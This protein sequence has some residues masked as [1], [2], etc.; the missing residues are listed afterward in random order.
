MI[1]LSEWND[2]HEQLSYLSSRV[3][4][5]QHSHSNRTLWIV[6]QSSHWN[7]S[8]HDKDTTLWHYL[9]CI[10]GVAIKTAQM[11]LLL[12]VFF[13]KCRCSPR[14]WWKYH[15]AIWLLPNVP[16]SNGPRCLGRNILLD[17]ILVRITSWAYSRKHS[18][19]LRLSIAENVEAAAQAPEALLTS[20]QLA[21]IRC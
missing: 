13:N 10:G 1:F 18:T 2:N 19:I 15:F 14:S 8:K 11:S 17:A 4:K 3:L 6:C 21:Y 20:P 5:L 7:H 16:S 9:F 12:R